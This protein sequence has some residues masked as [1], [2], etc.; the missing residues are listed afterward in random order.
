VLFSAAV[1]QAAA[2]F[3]SVGP[4][5]EIFVGVAIALLA[6]LIVT[7]LAV[8]RHNRRGSTT[9][10]IH[11]EVPVRSGAD[12]PV[13][14]YRNTPPSTS[15]AW[16]E[17]HEVLA[18][19]AAG[20]PRAVHPAMSGANF[21]SGPSGIQCFGGNSAYVVPFTNAA[22]EEWLLRFYQDP[23]APDQE[24]RYAAL[25][26]LA[27]STRTALGLPEVCWLDDFRG[28]TVAGGEPVPAVLMRRVDGLQLDRFVGEYFDE[29]SMMLAAATCLRD[30]L[31][32]FEAAGFAHG[33]LQD[34]NI[35]ISRA[36]G[37]IGVGF[38]DLDDVALP[39]LPPSTSV[40]HP[41]YQHPGR[42]QRDWGDHMDGF[43]G[44]LIWL[45]LRSI[46]AD[47]GL[48]EDFE[49]DG[50]LLFDASDLRQP[51]ETELW[52]CLA[53]SSDREVREGTDR[54]VKLCRQPDP[55]RTPFVELLPSW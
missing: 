49:D 14:E 26:Y 36:G 12:L 40:G 29:R 42:R 41:N 31:L 1:L 7:A 33:D 20:E 16:P 27:A 24:E 25:S 50:R 21:Y 4:R 28:Q 32:S 38:V 18:Y 43:S 45:A 15:A 5:V 9:N 55:P 2:H 6:I 46:A 52:R 35:F 3:L 8:A 19:L 11:G 10:S 39:G 37:D 22:D 47:P 13:P 51:G 54:L 53:R 17:R 30:R 34:G 23:P 44:L 48:W